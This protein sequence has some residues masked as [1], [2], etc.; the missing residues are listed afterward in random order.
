VRL[1]RDIANGNVHTVVCS[2]L[3][4]LFRSLQD[5]IRVLADWCDSGVRVVATSQQIDVDGQLGKKL[6]AVLLGVAEMEQVIR[7]ESQTAGIRAAKA[8]GAYSGRRVGTT[9]AKPTRARQLRDK[10]LST[11]KIAQA[12]GVSLRTVFRYLDADKR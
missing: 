11:G 6:P 5:G 12:L 10:G 7:R 3:D 1:Q 4:R 8:K 9:K 2:S